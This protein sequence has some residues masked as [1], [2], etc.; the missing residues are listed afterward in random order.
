MQVCGLPRQIIRNG[1]AASRLLA[2]KIPNIEAERRRDAPARWRRA[3]ANGLTAEQAAQA[4]GIPR[5]TLYRWEKSPEPRS[6]RPKRVRQ[7]KGPP[8]LVEAIEAVRADNPMW[9]KRKIAALLKREGQAVRVSK[10]GRILRRLMAR[11]AVVPVPILRRRPG[12]R[13]FRFDARQRHAKRLAKGER[14][15]R[16]DNSSRSTPSSS[17]SVPTG[18]SNT[19]PPTIRSPNGRSDTSQPP[20]PPAPQRPC[21]TSSSPARPSTSG[22]SRSTADPNSCPSSKTIAATKASNSSSCPPNAPISTDASKEPNRA[23]DTSSTHPTICPA[24]SINSSPSSTPSPTETTPT[25]PT[26]PLAI[27]PQPS[28]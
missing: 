17:T 1:F 12:G 14:R 27:K 24:A 7:P 8:A 6:R 21:S 15:K 20:H 13:R 5:S 4:V 11:G 19:S 3:M 10:V 26:R 16:P 2:V 28:I 23:G 18:R 25:D 9:G 22:E